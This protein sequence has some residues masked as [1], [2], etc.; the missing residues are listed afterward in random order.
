LPPV[1]MYWTTT[2]LNEADRERAKQPKGQFLI[3][4]SS[5]D[6]FPPTLFFWRRSSR[7]SVY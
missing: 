6:F 4:I 2:P 3:F 5:S 1:R 7:A